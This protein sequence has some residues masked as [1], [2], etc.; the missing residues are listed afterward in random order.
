VCCPNNTCNQN[1]LICVNGHCHPKQ[2]G[3]SSDGGNV[4][5][6]GL[7]DGG[8]QTCGHLQQTCCQGNFCYGQFTCLNGF[9]L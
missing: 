4:A 7:N 2:D 9:C 6:G 1:N 5:D 8:N 3:G